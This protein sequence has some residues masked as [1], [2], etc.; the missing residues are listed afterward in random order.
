MLFSVAQASMSL[1]ALD[2]AQLSSALALHSLP[3]SRFP[4]SASDFVHLEA[5]LLPQGPSY[6]DLSALFFGMTCLASF[7]PVLESRDLRALLVSRSS[8][9][10]GILPPVFDMG[11]LSM[12]PLPKSP[13]QSSFFLVASGIA[14]FGPVSLPSVM[15]C[16]TPE[17]FF[18]PH[19]FSRADA[20]TPVIDSTQTGPSLALRTSI[21]LRSFAT[22]LSVAKFELLPSVLDPA[23]LGSASPLKSFTWSRFLSFMP[24]CSHLDTLPPLH[25]ITRLKF[26]VSSSGVA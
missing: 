5:V 10:C 3:R 26:V 18:L 19:N 24:D 20:P 25:G 2:A 15:D 6:S 9:Q 4:V 17:S 23:C 22:L 7:M 8:A 13:S 12:P 16:V 14:Q 11:Y 1:L 21:H